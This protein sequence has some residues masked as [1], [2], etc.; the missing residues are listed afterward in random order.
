MCWLF[1]Y[2]RLRLESAFST[3]GR[4]LNEFRTSLTPFMVQALVCAQ[5]WLR[6]SITV[7]IEEDEEELLRL[8]KELI[9]EFGST[10][11]S[12]SKASSSK[13]VCK[14]SGAEPILPTSILYLNIDWL[15]WLELGMVKMLMFMMANWESYCW[16]L[17]NFKCKSIVIYHYQFVLLNT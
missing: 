2:Q 13:S 12:K 7:N 16:L 5:D 6:G 17:F 11:S 15:T 10:N 14:P 4:I 3:S 9:E 1:R 8:E